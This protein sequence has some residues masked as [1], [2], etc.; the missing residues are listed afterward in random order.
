MK[1]TLLEMLKQIRGFTIHLLENT[2]PDWVTWSPDGT[3]NHMIWHAGHAIWVEDLLCV[4]R[5]QGDSYLV[6]D[7][8]T[9]K[10]GQ[11]CDPVS[12]QTDW[13]TVDEM[14]N[15]LLDQQAKMT[16]LIEGMTPEQLVIDSENNRDL[17]GGM[18]HAMHDESKHQGEMYLLH[19]LAKV[20]FEG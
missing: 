7:A 4:K 19:K 16:E 18:I 9:S 20:K 1:S 13:P 6:D 10:F 8:W 2:N 5:L 17:V 12:E 3:S 14:K 11:H 15:A